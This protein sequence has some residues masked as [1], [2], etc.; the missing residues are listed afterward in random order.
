[1]DILGY[2]LL[3][4][5]FDINY[6]QESQSYFYTFKKYFLVFHINSNKMSNIFY[7]IQ[8]NRRISIILFTNYVTK[9]ENYLAY[10]ILNHQYYNITKFFFMHVM[11][12]LLASHKNI[13]NS[14][15]MVSSI[16]FKVMINTFHHI[17]IDY[18]QIY[19]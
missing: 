12:I 11:V 18:C 2:T 16:T 3:K 7:T 1:M 5:C 17:L 19:Y 13:S 15:P 8:E 9:I 6:C 14:S 10:Y 4:H